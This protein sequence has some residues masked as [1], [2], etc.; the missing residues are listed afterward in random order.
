MISE[1]FLFLI[2]DICFGEFCFFKALRHALITLWGFAVPSDLAT[3]SFIPSTSHT[4][5]KG[6]GIIAG[7]PVRAVCE[8]VSYT[9]L[10]LPTTSP[11]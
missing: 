8:A 3:M 2:I 1:I 4:A 5:P 11:V 9:H 6:T 7:G 10:T